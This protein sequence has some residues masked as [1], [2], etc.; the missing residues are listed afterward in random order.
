MTSLLIAGATG[1]TGGQVLESALADCRIKRVVA[2]TR[3]P[4]PPHPKLE[5]PL[6]DFERLPVAAA[7]WI[8]DAAVCALG[9]TRSIA[10]SS[11]AFRQVDYDYPL[12]I[13]RL[14]RERGARH[15]G[16]VSSSGANPKSALLYTRTKG[17]LEAAV[18]RL[19][20]PSLTIVRPGLIGGDRDEPRLAE[21]VTGVLLRAFTPLL[22]LSLR[23]S[24]VEHIVRVLLEGAVAALPGKILVSS[25]Q[26]AR[27][28]GWS[29]AA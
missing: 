6:V 10:G 11:A 24:P 29:T 19:S 14:V 5:N 21:R 28:S 20:F 18:A 12:T 2:P 9:T 4:L 1:L 3:R 13:A 27:P 17:E 8:V 25:A 15:F 16:L 7:W 22:P 26:L 23:I